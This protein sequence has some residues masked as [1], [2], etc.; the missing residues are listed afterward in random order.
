MSGSGDDNGNNS[1]LPT[2]VQTPVQ[3]PEKN[4][5]PETPT[6]EKKV[7]DAIDNPELASAKKLARTAEILEQPP[8]GEPSNIRSFARKVSSSSKGNVRKS[9]SDAQDLLNILKGNDDNKKEKV[10][11]M[12]ERGKN[13]ESQMASDR[14]STRL[15]SS[16][17]EL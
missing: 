2:I 12:L 8:A 14:K 11:K 7:K 15:N 16:H 5:Q 4:T 10:R 1:P 13:N 17:P 3:T 6:T 9:T